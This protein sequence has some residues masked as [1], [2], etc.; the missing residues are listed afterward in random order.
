M[1]SRKTKRTA[2]I[3]AV[4]LL[5]LLTLLS[6]L[7][8]SASTPE[9]PAFSGDIGKALVLYDKTHEKYLIEE[10][11]FNLVAT[12]TSAKITMGLIACETLSGRLDETV[13]VT[14]DM[15]RGT[16]GYNMKL[17]D[18]ERIKIRDLL[19]AAICGSYNDAAYALA[20]I[21]GGSSAGFVEMMNT[22]ALE[23]GAK[24]TSYTNPLGYP[25]N[26]AMLTTAYDVLKIALAASENPLYM[27][28][29]S[30][31]KHTI[32]ATNLSSERSFYNRNSLLSS[33]SSGANYFNSACLGMNAGY[34]GEE[35]GWSIVTLIRDTDKDESSVDYICVLLGGNENADGSR[36]YAYEHVDSLAR[37]ICRTYNNF[38]VL[39]AGKELGRMAIGLSMTSD[40]PYVTAEALKIYIPDKN[41]TDDIAYHVELDD[42]IRAPMKAGDAVGEV[43]V[44]ANGEKIGSCPLVLT[45]D[46]EV[47]GVMKVIDLIGSYTKSRAFIITIVCFVLI[48]GG[49][50]AYKYFTR[51]SSK[52]RYTRRR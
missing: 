32:S 7:P 16:A 40:A 22:R 38:E 31:V 27:E 39:P 4:L 21:C 45:E 46:Y 36:V 13:T 14:E 41:N 11:G 12:S 34:S 17:K 43:V 50:F 51:Y 6:T 2:I 26:A 35:G 25:D 23:L 18:G 49:Y 47:N 3:S 1:Q 20:S 42:G 28:L 8:I 10:G 52:G 29:C 33:S 48:L 15:I 9:P 19:Y 30:A 5:L 44:T 37:F 24:N